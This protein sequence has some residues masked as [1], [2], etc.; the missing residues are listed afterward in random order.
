MEKQNKKTNV[1]P[2][3]AVN[4][5]VQVLSFFSTFMVFIYKKII[6]PYMGSVYL[7]TVCYF[8][9]SAVTEI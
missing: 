2:L 4:T 6:I 3:N 1:V 9:E 5:L 7:Q 8:V